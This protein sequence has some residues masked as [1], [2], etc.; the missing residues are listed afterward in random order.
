MGKVFGN[1]KEPKPKIV[2]TL[3]GCLKTKIMVKELCNILEL[4]LST[5]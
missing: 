4:P 2:V 5:F 3:W 1:Q